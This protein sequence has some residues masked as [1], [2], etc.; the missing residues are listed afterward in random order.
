MELFI[1]VPYYI[2]MIL[3]KLEKNRGF[4]Q[5]RMFPGNKSGDGGLT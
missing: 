1:V 5:E 2:C 4:R 3:K